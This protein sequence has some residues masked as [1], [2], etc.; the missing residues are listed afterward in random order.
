[1]K[2]KKQNVSK[3]QESVFEL[4]EK[5]YGI[6]NVIASEE[7][8]EQS[9]VSSGSF[10]I[11][12][13]TKTGGIP[14]GK[15]MEIY[16]SE[17]SGKSTICLH[18]MSNFQTSFPERKVA[19]I[20]YEH[21]FNLNYAKKLGVNVKELL[22]YQPDNQE[23]GYD[24]I[25][26]LV[27]TNLV[28]LVVV[29]SQTAAIPKAVID[30]EMKDSVLGLQARN[31]SKFCGKIKGL[32]DF[33]NC[34]LIFISQTRANIGG[35]GYYNSE[36]S[37][38][39]NAIK[40][41]SDMRWKVTKNNDKI[42][43]RNVTKVEVVKN[44]VGPPFGTASIYINWGTGIDTDSEIIEL[45]SEFGFIEKSGSWY[46]VAGTKIQGEENVIQFMEDNL[47]YKISL[48]EKI[49]EKIKNEM[50]EDTSEKI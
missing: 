40:F 41:Y 32:L 43:N 34:T 25:I 14:L 44:K 1:M 45:A 28:S 36:I 26:N 17:G 37:T 24:F 3:D 18:I 20:D 11:D 21:S 42:N 4:L 47:E 46:T 10:M 30:G 15:L 31:N 22:V 39:G 8:S 27:K 5:K 12:R 35:M 23:E 33:N 6:L 50:Y 49:K 16:G 19:L 13:A 29:D 7:K 48:I 38:G 9:Y 2:T